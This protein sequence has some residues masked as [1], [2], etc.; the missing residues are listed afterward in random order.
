[1]PR[2]PWADAASWS[3]SWQQVLGVIQAPAGAPH[4]GTDFMRES[5]NLIYRTYTGL[6]LSG[7]Y[8]VTAVRTD[9]PG[10]LTLLELERDVAVVGQVVPLIRPEGS[11]RWQFLMNDATTE[12]LSRVAIPADTRATGRRAR[13]RKEEE[14]QRPSLRWW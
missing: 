8:A 10:I 12:K 6:R 4:L 7:R 9:T 2:V 5:T 11:D 14:E 13:K 1:M 3:S